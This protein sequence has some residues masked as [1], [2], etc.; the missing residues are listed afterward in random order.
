MFENIR[1][2]FHTEKRSLFLRGDVKHHLTSKL[3]DSKDVIFLETYLSHHLSLK[4]FKHPC[5]RGEAARVEKAAFGRAHSASSFYGTF[6]VLESLQLLLNGGS[7]NFTL[8]G[9]LKEIHENG[10]GGIRTLD[11]SVKSRLLYLAELQAQHARGE[12]NAFPIYCLSLDG[13]SI[14]DKYF[15]SILSVT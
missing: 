14:L 9:Q 3:F 1:R 11:P 4:K 10:L 12:N 13:V 2:L 5:G 8:T 7:R 6:I 15:L